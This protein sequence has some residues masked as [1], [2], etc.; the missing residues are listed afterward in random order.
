MNILAHVPA[1]QAVAASARRRAASLAAPHSPVALYSEPAAAHATEEVA[2]RARGLATSGSRHRTAAAPAAA[3]AAERRPRARAAVAPPRHGRSRPRR[4]RH[5]SAAARDQLAGSWLR[6][7][8]A[9]RLRRGRGSVGPR[10][11][12]VGGR[13]RRPRSR[14]RRRPSPPVRPL[15]LAL[16]LVPALSCVARC[17]RGVHTRARARGALGP[18]PAYGGRVAAGVVRCAAA[19]CSC[20]AAKCSA[21]APVASLQ[22]GCSST[23]L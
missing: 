12:A 20:S 22:A 7:P 9:L 16:Q 13:W 6:S 1:G 5:R 4:R 15:A 17:Q 14:Q 3:A 23:A 10:A 18:R 2:V 19:S 8:Y 21:M 11:P